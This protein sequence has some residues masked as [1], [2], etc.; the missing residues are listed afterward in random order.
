MRRVFLSEHPDVGLVIPN[1]NT[2]YVDAIRKLVE[3]ANFRPYEARARVF[4][5]DEAEKLGLTQKAAA[6]ALLKTLEEP[7]PTTHI[8]LITSKPSTILQTI[9]SRCQTIRFAPVEDSLIAEHLVE[10]NSIPETDAVLLSKI[11]K[12]S[13][14]RASAIDL[15][16]YRTLRGRLL[17]VI[18]TAVHGRRLANVLRVSEEIAGLKEADGYDTSLD[19]LETMIRDM[20]LILK[21]RRGEITHVDLEPV[22]NKLSQA[23][24]FARASVWIEE[25]EKVKASLRI[26]INKKIG[27]DAL[28]V[29]MATG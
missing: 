10:T 27:A 6:N 17:E 22:L 21:D 25:I 11:A 26:N 29:K 24:T 8:I 12:G 23:I 16:E 28:F 14:A 9:H 15:E 3:E 20:I 18:E 13:F 5:I 4:I 1:R 19:I 7:A 2:I